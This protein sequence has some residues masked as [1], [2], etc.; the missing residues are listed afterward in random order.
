MSEQEML[1][2]NWRN[3]EIIPV[4]KV[5]QEVEF[6][7]AVEI[8]RP[9]KCAKVFTFLSQYQNR[10][11][12]DGDEDLGGEDALV[13][14]NGDYVDSVGWVTC[15]SHNQFDNYYEPIQFSDDY[16]LLGWSEYVAPKFT[17]MDKL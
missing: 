16:K 17:R 11:Y 3:P 4:V 12:I 13:N 2:L 10:P 8:T 9:N 5:G 15:Q 1:E 14:T 7:I 6:W